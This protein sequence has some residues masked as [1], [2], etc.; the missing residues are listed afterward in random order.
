MRRPLLVVIAGTAL[1][2]GGVFVIAAVAPDLLRTPQTLRV[3]DF[4]AYWTA[5]KVNLAGQDAYTQ[6]NLLKLQQAIEPHSTNP[7]AAWSPPWT[8][9]VFTPLAPLDFAVARW[10]WRFLQ[11][12]TILAAVTMLWRVY[13]GNRDRIIW[14]WFATLVWYPS[15]QALGLGQ[16]SNIVLLGVTGWIVGLA[17]GRS[18]AAGAMLA[19]TLVKPQNVYLVGLLAVV[20]VIDRRAWLAAAGGVFGTALLSAI[21]AIPNPTV[22]QDYVDAMTSRPPTT[23]LPPTLGMLMRLVFGERYFWLLFVPQVVGVGWALWYYFRHRRGWDWA[24]HGPLVVLVSCL[25]SPYG[26]MYDQVLVLIPLVAVLAPRSHKPNKFILGVA[27]VALLTAVCL[28]LHGARFR[29]I[30]FVWHAPLCLGLY[31]ALGLGAASL[32]DGAS[33][34][35]TDDYGS[36][37]PLNPS[38]TT[39]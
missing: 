38:R 16:H 39:R 28:A 2:V 20:W 33:K 12:G 3:E 14:V 15:L 7:I 24:N 21:A 26:W 30:T 34:T 23:A 5:T 36:E 4:G 6:D 13:G 1:A 17:T 8:F 25:T 18:F 27:L 35:V 32:N 19:L 10:V 29:E 31:L 22:F 9:A 11:I 37:E